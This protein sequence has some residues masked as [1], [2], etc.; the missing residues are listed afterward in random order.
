LGKSWTDTSIA[1]I[2]FT[3]PLLSGQNLRQTKKFF[4]GNNLF[5]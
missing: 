1:A 2:D 4:F 5:A 3:P